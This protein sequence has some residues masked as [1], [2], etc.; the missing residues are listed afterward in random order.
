VVVS[1]TWE[2]QTKSYCT[3]IIELKAVI[4]GIIPLL[5]R[6]IIIALPDLELYAIG[7]IYRDRSLITHDKTG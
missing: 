5:R 2:S 1:D 3:L 4:I 6:E 7:R